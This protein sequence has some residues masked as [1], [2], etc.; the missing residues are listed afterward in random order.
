MEPK[1]AIAAI[2]ASIR[3]TYG[4]RGE[5][6]VNRNIEAVDNSLAAL[7]RGFR[8]RS[9]LVRRE[10]RRRWCPRTPPSSCAP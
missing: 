3:K 1:Q 2:K 6:V 9:R 7:H 8:P 5:E 10:S 4:K